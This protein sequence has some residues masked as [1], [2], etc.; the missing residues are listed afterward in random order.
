M[1][2]NQNRKSLENTNAFRSSMQLLPVPKHLRRSTVNTPFVPAVE[3]G[4]QAA[5][6]RKDNAKTQFSALE[7]T[8]LKIP[9]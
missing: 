9:H 4:G 6:S 2:V 7:K 5:F 8:N 3:R 1:K